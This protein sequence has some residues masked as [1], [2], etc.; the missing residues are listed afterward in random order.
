[1][2]ALAEPDYGAWIEYPEFK[3]GQYHSET[4]IN[5]GADPYIG[6]KLKSLFESA[7][8]ETTISV[9]AQVW[10]KESLSANIEEEWKRVYEAQLISSED[11]KRR[12]TMEKEAISLNTRMIFMPV[13]TSIGRKR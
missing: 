6:R 5:E 11:L 4:L 3:L 1:M 13:F 12:I 8:L 10:D 2:V 9:I 7:D